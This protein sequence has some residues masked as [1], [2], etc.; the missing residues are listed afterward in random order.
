MSL[1]TVPLSV[2]L[3]CGCAW[4]ILAT[5]TP[6]A[7]H[8][9]QL[10]TGCFALRAGRAE[11]RRGHT[12]DR[13][14]WAQADSPWPP[15]GIRAYSPQLAVVDVTIIVLA[16][17]TAQLLST[18]H[19]AHMLPPPLPAPPALLPA[20]PPD[21]PLSPRQPMA[22]LVRRFITL[23]PCD[24]RMSCQARHCTHK[25]VRRNATR[26]R[27][28]P[29]ICTGALALYP[30]S[31]QRLADA[32]RPHAAGP[33][34]KALGG[35]LL[36]IPANV[37]DMWRTKSA[38]VLLQAGLPFGLCDAAAWRSVFLLISG[39]RFDGPGGRRAVGRA[40]L[41]SAVA[42]V[43]SILARFLEGCH[44]VSLSIGGMTDASRGGVYNV[45]IYTPRPFSVATFR[46]GSDPITA[47]NL[48]TRLQGALQAPLLYSF[49]TSAT[50]ELAAGA[51]VFSLFGHRRVL[52][53][54]TGSPTTMV[55][56]RGM[57][58]ARGSFLFALGCGAH[59]GNLVAQDAARVPI[60]AQ[61][62][63]AAL[64]ITF[65]FCAID[66]R[67]LAPEGRAGASAGRG[68]T[69]GVP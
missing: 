28:H 61:A 43:D 9:E 49:A 59:A 32:N 11:D 14:R 39:G 62:L 65:F 29:R 6:K 18:T 16:S 19:L 23:H 5:Q 35:A 25:N 33:V 58:V 38:A 57:A 69:H 3:L 7:A 4:R 1:T 45:V 56:L 37:F 64:L 67:T 34:A 24:Q 15:R 30:D 10:Q 63:R 22:S 48:L 20:S 55:A 2:A 21:D 52:A 36:P 40:L 8:R 60:F 50:T 41:T 13:V 46:M 17:S 54:E 27:R 66:A 44:S 31:D 42:V 12:G 47:A 26:A 68:S 53:L 51:S